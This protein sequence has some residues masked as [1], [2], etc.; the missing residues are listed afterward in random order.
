MRFGYYSP[1]GKRV[2]AS[3][4]IPSRPGGGS[5]PRIAR[6][7]TPGGEPRAAAPTWLNCGGTVRGGA[8]AVA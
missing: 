1:S 8:A 7:R 2:G 4:G 6:R 5:R 3:G